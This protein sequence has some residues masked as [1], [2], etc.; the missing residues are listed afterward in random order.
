MHSGNWVTRNAAG[1]ENILPFP[2]RIGIGI[3]PLHYDILKIKGDKMKR[4]RQTIKAG[5]RG[6]AKYVQKYGLNLLFVRY[7]YDWE[8]KR[9]ITTAEVIIDKKDWIPKKIK[10]TT[11][12][13]VKV[14]W[15]ETGIRQSIKANGGKWNS[16]R[17]LWEIP[18]GKVKELG[19]QRRI[20]R[21]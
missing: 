10:P 17:K 7:Y 13:K 18:F 5:E 20:I 1:G 8:K 14:D 15:A 4:T 11:I 19:L 9:R 6:T 21:K 2:F 16:E 12:V 3:L